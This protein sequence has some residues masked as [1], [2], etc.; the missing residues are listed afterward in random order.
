MFPK[1]SQKPKQQGAKFSTRCAKFYIY[2]ST[3]PERYFHRI[4]EIRAPVPRY[5]AAYLKSDRNTFP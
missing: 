5:K 1:T 2:L 4:L 3:R